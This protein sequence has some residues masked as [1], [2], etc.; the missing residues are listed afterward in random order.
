MVKHNTHIDRIVRTQLTYNTT[1]KL[2][3][4][5]S[6][7]DNKFSYNMFKY[8]TEL[9]TDDVI[10]YYP[11]QD[12]AYDLLEQFTQVD[13]EY[14]VLYDGSDRAIRN[15]FQVYVT[16]GS[17]VITTDPSFPMYS[18]YA[19]MYQAELYTA[20]YSTTDFPFVDV[21]TA[22]DSNTNLV[23]LSNPSSPIGTVIS[24]E[25]LL[26][27]LAHCERHD[28][29]LAVDEA[30]IEFSNAAS[31]VD[32]A[33][34]H[35]NLIVIRTLSKAVG[36]AGARI[37]YT[38][39][40]KPNRELLYKLRNMNDITGPSIAWLDTLVKFKNEVNAYVKDVIA[41]RNDLIAKLRE[42]NILCLPSETNFIHAKISIENCSY[43][44][45]NI[46]G[47]ECVRISVPGDKGNYKQLLQIIGVS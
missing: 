4:H 41:N 17:R 47:Q 28:C 21:L 8:Y 5:A 18:V 38:V 44:A 24:R 25:Q 6:E 14:T 13:K 43:K 30:Y 45:C 20:K 3:L 23:I 39:S 35:P 16:Q 33:P 31:L 11:N 29:V 37:G 2:R 9:L 46:L 15:I 22:I 1:D 7:R 34:T 42:H 36:S 10:R 32:L 26:C 27:L 19:D 40:D 12:R